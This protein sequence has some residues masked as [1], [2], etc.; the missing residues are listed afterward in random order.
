MEA[1]S[2]FDQILSYSNKKELDNPLMNY[3]IS[4]IVKLHPDASRNFKIGKTMM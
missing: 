3:S 2:T 1:I 4:D